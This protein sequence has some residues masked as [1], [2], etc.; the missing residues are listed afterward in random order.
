MAHAGISSIAQRKFPFVVI[1]NKVDEKDIKVCLLSSLLPLF[2]LFYSC[3]F[4]LLYLILLDDSNFY[5]GEQEGGGGV[6]QGEEHTTFLCIC[7][8]KQKRKHFN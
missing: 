8:D 1:G 6:V 5:S 3:S 4:T 2:T 7:K